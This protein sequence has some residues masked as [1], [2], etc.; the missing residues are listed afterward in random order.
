[1]VAVPNK[2]FG[3][4]EAARDQIKQEQTKVQVYLCKLPNLFVQIAK[5]FVY[6]KILHGEACLLTQFLS[7][8][9]DIYD[10]SDNIFVQIINTFV[11]FAQIAER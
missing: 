7:S 8:H 1:M 11:K 9:I 5:Y 2:I 6:K 10:K 4:Q 3:L